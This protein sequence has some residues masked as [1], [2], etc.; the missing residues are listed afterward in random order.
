M[1]RMVWLVILFI[2]ARVDAQVSEGRLFVSYN[3]TV[4]IIFPYSIVSEDHGSGGV[5]TQQKKSAPKILQVKANQKN[6]APTNLSVVTSDGHVYSFIVEY[7]DDVYRLNYI[8]EAEDAIAVTEVPHNEE[9]LYEEAQ[10]V[11]N[12]AR[13][14]RKRVSDDFSILQLRGLFITPNALWLTSRFINCTMVPYPIGFVK[15]FIRDKKR[16]KNAAVQEREIFPIYSQVP[17]LFAGKAIDD[18]LLAFDPFVV[19][20]HQQLI[21]QVGEL[22]GNRFTQLRIKPKHFRRT[23]PLPRNN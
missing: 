20:K 9:Y 23:R 8:M 12:A 14:I 15:F 21:M 22:N 2:A 17:E 4:N 19:K 18:L 6:F 10:L 3:K 13:H 16:T 1:K 11:K 7:A 5:I